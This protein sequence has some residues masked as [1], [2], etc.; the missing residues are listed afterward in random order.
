MDL[1]KEANKNGRGPGVS[2]LVLWIEDEE[3]VWMGWGIGERRI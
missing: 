3:A 1:P 2:W